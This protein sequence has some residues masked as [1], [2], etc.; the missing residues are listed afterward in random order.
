MSTRKFKITYV[1]Q[2][3]FL[4]GSTGIYS[5]YPEI[6]LLGYKVFDCSILEN[7]SKLD[8][9]INITRKYIKM[10]VPR[11]LRTLNQKLWRCGPTFCILT[12]SPS[13]T[14]SNLRDHWPSVLRL[15]S[16][17]KKVSHFRKGSPIFGKL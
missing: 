4:L 1:A 15:Y 17:L 2:L 5:I 10:Q 8:I 13:N 6:D 14:N 16:V 7:N 9:G 12:C 11:P 3:S